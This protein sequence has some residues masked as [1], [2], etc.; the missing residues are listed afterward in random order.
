MRLERAVSIK[1]GL[2][3]Y[4][5]GTNEPRRS[6]R[7]PQERI[8]IESYRDLF[9]AIGGRATLER[10]HKRFYDE[11]FQHEWLGQFFTGIEQAF[12]EEQQTDFM[13][14]IMGGP[15]CYTGQAPKAAHVHMFLT[16]E[17]FDLRSA[18]LDAAIRAEGV[19]DEA[20]AAWI[21]LDQSFRQALVKES[22]E[23][24]RP[25]YVF[26]DVVVVPTG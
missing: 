7:S 9:T 20:R 21:A 8:Q 5:K 12:I 10:V 14:S 2:S 23:E 25:R 3:G 26:E 13:S 18:L 1:I 16:D 22:P 11:L 15:R 4:R 17:I 19:D 24:C 6:P